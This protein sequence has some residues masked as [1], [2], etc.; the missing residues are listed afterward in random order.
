MQKCLLGIVE[1][2]GIDNMPSST[3]HVRGMYEVHGNY[4][5]SW[6]VRSHVL[7]FALLPEDKPGKPP[8][9]L[10]WMQRHARTPYCIQDGPI[11]ESQA[12]PARML[13]PYASVGTH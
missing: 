7:L 11:D 8:R 1:A 2:K 12:S 3:E 6:T 10:P 4:G 13:H 9:W 5:V